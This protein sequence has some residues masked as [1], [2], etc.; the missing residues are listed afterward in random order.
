MA[1]AAGFN[2]DAHLPGCRLCQSSL[3]ESKNAR[4]CD[5]NS[6]VCPVHNIT[7]FASHLFGYYR[8]NSPIFIVP[9]GLNE[10]SPFGGYL[11]SRTEAQW[12]SRVRHWQG[13]RC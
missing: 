4:A 5:L 10:N 13:V 8:A 6:L 3:S 9:K 7:I 11:I 1:N 2:T 12:K